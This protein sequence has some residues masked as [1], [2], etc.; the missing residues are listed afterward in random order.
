MKE[1]NVKQAK[2]SQSVASAG[3]GLGGRAPSY[4]NNRFRDFSKYEVKSLG[5]RL[6]FKF[7]TGTKLPM[8]GL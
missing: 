8:S 1:L 3:R 6:L 7:L 4:F 2:L 5:G